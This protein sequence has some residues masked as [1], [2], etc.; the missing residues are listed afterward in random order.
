MLW[1]LLALLPI[2]LRFL[3]LLALP[4]ITNLCRIF[5]DDLG[6]FWGFT[7]CKGFEFS[8]DAASLVFFSTFWGNIGA[9]AGAEGGMQ[10]PEL[11]KQSSTNI[12]SHSK[13]ISPSCIICDTNIGMTQKISKIEAGMTREKDPLF[14][15]P[16]FFD[17]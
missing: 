11:D 4:G 2:G 17:C 16:F 9:G 8:A 10:F 12:D 7:N 6:F 3:L 13:F 14:F 15:F 1:L 5:D